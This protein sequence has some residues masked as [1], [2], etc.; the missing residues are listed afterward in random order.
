MLPIRCPFFVVGEEGGIGDT[1]KNISS[2]GNGHN[3]TRNS[4]QIRLSV[5]LRRGTKSLRQTWM[6]NLKSNSKVTISF[7]S[8]YLLLWKFSVAFISFWFLLQSPNYYNLT[9]FLKVFMN[10]PPWHITLEIVGNLIIKLWQLKTKLILNWLINLIQS[11]LS[12]YSEIFFV[13]FLLDFTVIVFRW[14]TDQQS[15][16]SHDRCFSFFLFVE[17]GF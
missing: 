4:Q 8:S 10:P 2:L 9:F 7:F 17:I 12:L 5:T 15:S 16:V 1:T 13:L 3:L 6:L 14:W 11:C